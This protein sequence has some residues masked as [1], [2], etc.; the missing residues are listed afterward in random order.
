MTSF[1]PSPYIDF[2]TGVV[3]VP[4]MA[5]IESWGPR[6]NQSIDQM[7]MIF[8][9]RVDVWQLGPAVE[10]LKLM[11]VAHEQTSVWAHSGYA[12]LAMVFS[13]FEMIGKI[14]NPRSNSWRT[15]KEDFNHGFCDVYPSFAPVGPERTDKAVPSVA[16]F[17]DRVRNGMYHLGYTK[18]HL[19]IHNAPHKFPNDF[20]VVTQNDERFYFV[21]PHALVRVVVAH[22]PSL[23]DRLK[24]RS[25]EFDRLRTQFRDFYVS[26]HEGVPDRADVR[27]T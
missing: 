19:F 11:D 21:N 5:L 9:C 23:M 14:L 20:T 8:E 15:S 3:R 24:N 10:M 1:R 25:A 13:Y 4:P 22:F 7:L 12:L 26:F 17:R 2:D 16:Q 27:P 18:S 6:T